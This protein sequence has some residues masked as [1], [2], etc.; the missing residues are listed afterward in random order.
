M[1]YLTTYRV[2]VVSR[3]LPPAFGG[4]ALRAY[5]YAGRLERINRLGLL[6]GEGRNPDVNELMEVGGTEDINRKRVAILNENPLLQRAV[7]RGGGISL[8][9][10]LVRVTSLYLSMIFCFFRRRHSFDIVHCFGAGSWLSLFA[11]NV[12]QMLGKKTILEMTL[13]GSD[14]PLGIRSQGGNFGRRIRSY[15]FSKADVVV[16]K[17]PA[18]S[19]AYLKSN[20]HQE[21]LVEIHNPVDTKTF[22]PASEI[23]KAT[24]RSQLGLSSNTPIILYVGAIVQ[25]KGIELLIKSFANI[26]SDYPKA[27]LLLIGPIGQH[28][29]N[30][31]YAEEMRKL[32]D[33]VVS[34][35]QVVFRGLVSN[36]HDYMRASDIFV[37]ASIREGFPNVVVESMASGIPAVV[38]NIHGIT[39]GIITDGIDGITV[40]SNSP[41]TFASGIK[42]LL[43]DKEYYS[44][45][46][47][48]ARRKAIENYSTG[49]IDAKYL[50]L[51]EALLNT[52]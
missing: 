46:A 38:L 2:C 50:Q 12:G 19:S 16:S 27:L 8:I 34:G 42:Q 21:K 3:A 7:R 22:C 1:D 20:L 49:V 18:L 45:L 36:V 30:I 28:Q 17:S 9:Q 48:N 33:V 41:D 25:R 24:L 5:R 13:L 51:Y 29:G 15:L 31:S 10:N 23:E 44:F 39:N 47:G 14:D 11:V 32:A 52:G 37:F 6:V 4:G 43:E 35:K 26:V 40:N